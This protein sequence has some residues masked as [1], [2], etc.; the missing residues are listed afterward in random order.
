MPKWKRDL[1]LK[2]KGLLSDKE[3]TFDDTLPR[4]RRGGRYDR[5]RRESRY[6]DDE[7]STRKKRDYSDDDRDRRRKRHSN[8]YSDDERDRRRRGRRDSRD[9]DDDRSGRKGK[10]RK[11]RGRKRSR[12]RKESRSRPYS[13]EDE[14]HRDRKEKKSKSKRG[15]RSDGYSDEED[16][17][18]GRKTSQRRDSYNDSKKRRNKK[19]GPTNVDDFDTDEYSDTS[20]SYSSSEYSDSDY[21]TSASESDDS[22]KA[23]I[24]SSASAS[25]LTNATW[26]LGAT[27]AGTE[28]DD[29]DERVKSQQEE[30]KQQLVALSE[31]QKKVGAKSLQVHQHTMLQ[32]DLQ[33]LEQ[34]QTKL[35]NTPDDQTLQMQLLGQQTLLIEHLKEIIEE[36]EGGRK[37]IVKSKSSH[38]IKSSVGKDGQLDTQQHQLH[39]QHQLQQQMQLQALADQQRQQM[40]IEH[41]RQLEAEQ[42]RQLMMAEQ[43][44]QMQLAQL[45]SMQSPSVFMSPRSPYGMAGMSYSPYTGTVGYY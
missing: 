43:Q 12:S 9:R 39:H 26:A 10:R 14:K 2:K 17:K 11:D 32:Q 8:A 16:R 18:R 6:S 13:D 33:K 22:R 40:L 5:S 44:R 36:L 7:R 31:T 41:H 29:L 42:Q 25:E 24:K 27:A 19:R 45:S 23:K 35:K 37:E 3:T 38:S 21:S 28:K 1:L 4:G 34:L 20:E 15:D 30:I